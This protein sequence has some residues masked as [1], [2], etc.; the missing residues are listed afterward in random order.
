MVLMILVLGGT[1]EGRRLSRALTDAGVRHTLSLAGRTNIEP[2][3]NSRVGGFGGVAGLVAYLQSNEIS[4]VIDA[5]HPFANRMHWNAHE[6]CLKAAVPLLRLGRPGWKNHRHA[7]SW[8]WVG[9]HEEAVETLPVDATVLLTVGRQEAARYSNHPG[10]VIVRVAEAPDEWCRTIPAG[11]EVIEARGP[12]ALSD[13]KALL[14]RVDALI[15]KD[16]GG[17]FNEPKLDAAHELGVSVVMIARPTSPP[18]DECTRVEDAVR[19]AV[20]HSRPSPAT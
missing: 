3:P 17:S 18:A 16:S 11:W 9:S 8:H 6:G 10:P 20:D 15:S 7:S 5:T 2:G 19:W 12:F 13:E 14:A 4:G 1:T